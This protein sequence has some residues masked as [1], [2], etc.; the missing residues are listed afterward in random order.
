MPDPT[1]KIDS[2]TVLSKSGTTVS[3][4]SGV[5]FPAGMVISHQIKQD[6][7]AASNYSSTTYVE[8]ASVLRI[9]VTPQNSSSTL[10]FRM[11]FQGALANN[12][13]LNV[14]IY[15]DNGD[16]NAPDTHF[17]DTVTGIGSLR[18][19]KAANELFGA[20]IT[21]MLAP[22]NMFTNTRIVSP[23]FRS[24][25]GNAVKIANSAY[26]GKTFEVIEIAG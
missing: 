11:G 21:F 23:F 22:T 16:G 19:G 18:M 14:A 6:F 10:I 17:G 1:F 7:T 26:N 3:I 13:D 8:M 20:T 12:T 4:D 2:T 24:S 25:N 15:H 5:K 9:T